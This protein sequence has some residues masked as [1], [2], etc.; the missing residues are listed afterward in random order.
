VEFPGHSNKAR[1][2]KKW[3]SNRKERSQ[4]IPIADDTILHLK[5]PKDSTKNSWI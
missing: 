3:D 4:I 1:E 2:R 5:D